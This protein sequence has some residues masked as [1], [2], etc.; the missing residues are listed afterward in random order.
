MLLQPLALA[1]LVLE[2]SVHKAWLGVRSHLALMQACYLAG[3]LH[4]VVHF[5]GTRHHLAEKHA[6]LNGHNAHADTLWPCAPIPRLLL[7]RGDSSQ[8]RFSPKSTS[9]RTAEQ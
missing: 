2:V 3:L 1:G 8:Q 4:V 9:K 5:N 7:C 6:R